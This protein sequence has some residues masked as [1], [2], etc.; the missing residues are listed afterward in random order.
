MLLRRFDESF[1]ANGC[2]ICATLLDDFVS[3]NHAVTVGLKAKA[4]PNQVGF[5]I[6]SFRMSFCAY[7]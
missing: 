1:E 2:N 5:P 7:A 3:P 4:A 6:W